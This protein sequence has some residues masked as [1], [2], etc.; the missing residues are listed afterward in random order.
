MSALPYQTLSSYE[1]TLKK[2]IALKPQHIS[3]YSLILEEGTPLFD[4]INNGNESLLP[5]E[6]TEREMYYL[7]DNILKDASYQR[8]EISNYSKTGYECRHNLSY[9]DRVDYLGLGLGASSLVDSTRYKNTDSLSFYMENSHNPTAIK[10]DITPLSKK[11]IM[12]EFMFLGLRKIKGIS[13]NAFNQQF[14]MDIFDVYGD[15][16][17]KYKNMNLLS[18]K[19][20]VIALTK[21][22]L[23][24][25]NS[26]FSDF[27]IDED[28]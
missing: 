22:G 9:W 7:T 13:I 26:I 18:V 6:D 16:I 14:G 2:V 28:I 10:C 1:D 27:L 12:E 24:V 5:D 15:V 19:N 4:F 23:D 21:Q 3:A 17:T 11:D 8:Y 25:S 20:D